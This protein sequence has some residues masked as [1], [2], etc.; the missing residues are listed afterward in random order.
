MS[1][2]SV[3]PSLFTIRLLDGFAVGCADRAVD[4][5]PS[6]QRLVAYLALRIGAGRSAAA[7]VLWPGASDEKSQASLRTAVW[8][9]NRAAPGLVVTRG[10][11]VA[12]A[13]DTVVDNREFT[14]RIRR[15]LRPT[16]GGQPP[17]VDE[18]GYAWLLRG[19]E[20]L[21]G[22]YDDWVLLEQE[23][24]RQLRL[25]ALEAAAHRMAAHGSYAGALELAFEA[26]RLEPLRES[27]NRAVIAVHQSEGN[28][29]DAVRHYEWFRRLLDAELGLR[30]SARLTALA[31]G[32][33]VPPARP[34]R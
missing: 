21:P 14:V 30:P 8:R 34:H 16:S 6:G 2:P 18:D 25:H 5:P 17:P 33:V 3:G 4:V 19:G 20:L 1:V 32:Q 24:T 26:V 23:Y 12:L 7:A 27:A 31:R 28:A 22:W 13:P 11:H 15:M 10:I 9:V 29:V